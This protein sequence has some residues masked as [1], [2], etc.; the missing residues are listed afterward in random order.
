MSV[1]YTIYLGLFNKMKI[2][3]KGGFCEFGGK[4][5]LHVYNSLG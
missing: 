3:C 4:R 1:T 2:I 5:K